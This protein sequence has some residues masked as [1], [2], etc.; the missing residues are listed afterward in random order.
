MSPDPGCTVAKS[1]VVLEPVSSSD[2][3][4]PGVWRTQLVTSAMDML[5]KY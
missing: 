2:C 1:D 3:G 5:D 4:P